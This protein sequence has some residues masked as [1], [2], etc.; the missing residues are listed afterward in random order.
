MPTLKLNKIRKAV[1]Q[2]ALEYPIKRVELFGS[3]ADGTADAESDVDF[4]VEFNE[5]PTSL[6]HIC[7]FRETLSE[8]LHVDVDIVK[9]PRKENDGLTIDRTVKM[10]GA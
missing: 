1:E 7:G 6:L 10:Y 3:Y 5:N 2:A 4:L 9:L 8:L